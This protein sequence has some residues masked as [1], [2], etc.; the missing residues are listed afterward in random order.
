MVRELRRLEQE[1]DVSSEHGI[2]YLSTISAAYLLTPA[3][4]K[5]IMKIILTITQYMVWFSDY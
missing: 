5:N 1:S 2:A 4:W 3:D